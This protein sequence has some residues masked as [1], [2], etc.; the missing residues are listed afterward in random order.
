MVLH[1]MYANLL[2]LK[3][4]K[5]IWRGSVWW[6]I[7]FFL[8]FHAVNVIYCWIQHKARH[9]IWIKSRKRE[10][11]KEKIHLWW[12][13]RKTRK[14]GAFSINSINSKSITHSYSCENWMLLRHTH[15]CRYW[16]NRKYKCMCTCMHTSVSLLPILTTQNERI[17]EKQQQT[18]TSFK[19]SNM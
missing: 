3:P 1:S 10:R 12:Q 7:F 16:N 13:I 18:N 19:F 15:S 8:H 6:G 5:F 14:N 2:Q 9:N 11:E 4:I 17:T